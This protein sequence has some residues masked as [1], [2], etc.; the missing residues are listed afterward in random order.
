MAK[1][2]EQPKPQLY[3]YKNKVFYKHKEPNVFVY[4]V[5]IFKH[6]TEGKYYRMELLG[7]DMFE[8]DKFLGLTLRQFKDSKEAGVRYSKDVSLVAA[9]QEFINS[10]HAQQFVYEEK[11]AKKVA[12]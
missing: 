6:T 10:N 8:V 2:E 4:K 3:K 7:T 12:S 1:K 11:K 9:P 5:Q